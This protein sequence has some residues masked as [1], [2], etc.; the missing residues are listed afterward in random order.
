[1][2]KKIGKKLKAL[3]LEKKM[4]KNDFYKAVGIKSETLKKY[5]DGSIL[6]PI[7]KLEKIISF[8]NIPLYLFFLDL[9]IED[10]SNKNEKLLSLK[11]TLLKELD[12]I[13]DILNK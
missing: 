10:K 9:D 4:S 1:M 2:K 12:K 3:R 7:D 11:N 6:I 13:Q 5:E 8:Y